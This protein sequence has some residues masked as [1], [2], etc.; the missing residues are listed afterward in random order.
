MCK[1][2]P[3]SILRY[4][5]PAPLPGIIAAW[6]ISISEVRLDLVFPLFRYSVSSLLSYVA[7]SLS[8]STG[9]N[10]PALPLFLAV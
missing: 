3:P 6:Q 4:T 5:S 2:V 1:R 7:S 10:R 9:K 8:A